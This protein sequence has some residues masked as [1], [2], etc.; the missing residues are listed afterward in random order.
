MISEKEPEDNKKQV[1]PSEI[2]AYEEGIKDALTMLAVW[3][4]GAEVLGI[5]ETPL[6]TALANIK[7]YMGQFYNKKYLISKV[8]KL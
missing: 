5:K 8:K 6:K 4:R 1:T 7:V 2:A 3:K